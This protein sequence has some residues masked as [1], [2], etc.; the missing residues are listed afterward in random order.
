MININY[1]DPR[2]I[3][4][5]VKDTFRQLIISGALPPDEKLPSVR[6]LAAIPEMNRNVAKVVYAFFHD[7]EIPEDE[8]E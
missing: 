8:D 2:P 1:R 3:Y 6:E 5:Q 4:E 7:G